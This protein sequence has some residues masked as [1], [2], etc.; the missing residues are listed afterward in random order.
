[1]LNVFINREDKGP[2]PQKTR[3]S[4]GDTIKHN[5]HS[6]QVL[7]EIGRGGFAHVYSIK[8]HKGNIF[9]LKILDL[10]TVRQNEH[11]ALIAKFTQEYNAG[12]IKSSFTARSY[13]QG[14]IG[15]NPYI[16]MDYC[17][18]G[19]LANRMKDFFEVEKFESLATAILSGLKDLHQ[20]GIIHRDLKPEKVLFDQNDQPNL[21][22][23][24]IAGHLNSRLTRKN[25]I[26]MVGDVWGTPLYSSPEQLNHQKAYKHTAPTMD[27]FSFG[28]MM[29]EVISGG[30]HPFGDHKDLLANPEKYLEKVTKGAI[31]PINYY[32]QDIPTYWPTIINKCIK[33]NPLNRYESVNEIIT[34][35]NKSKPIVN[36]ILNENSLQTDGHHAIL[37]VMEG[38]NVG[39]IYYLMPLVE[40]KQKN[41]LNIGWLDPEED[42]NDIGILESNSR[43][44]S[45]NHATLL[46]VDNGWELSDGCVDEVKELFISSKNGT[47]VNYKNISKGE[48][49]R[50]K[51]G[52][53][54]SLGNTR[55]K[56]KTL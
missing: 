39:H 3:L 10:W 6:Y 53:L 11:P 38:D 28:I 23:F 25:I 33:H 18:N 52:D 35:L 13:L 30:H 50:L 42:L 55:L 9:A 54:I 40:S 24:G 22:D 32:R 31:V 12:K 37:K 7:S 15:D 29:Y 27:I 48:R 44:I 34:I 46:K 8:D 56:F 20:E 45:R 16:I 21:T 1:M 14:E 26:G 51:D 5:N 47:Y 2:I 49:Y 17:P 4:F 43:Y 41:I 19:S 36:E